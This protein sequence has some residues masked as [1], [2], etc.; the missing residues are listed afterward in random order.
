MSNSKSLTIIIDNPSWPKNKPPKELLARTSTT[1]EIEGEQK[2]AL[3]AD[4]LGMH[5]F[6]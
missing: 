1:L 3:V 6:A 2:P 4:W 5:F